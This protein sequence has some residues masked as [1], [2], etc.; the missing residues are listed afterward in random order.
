MAVSGAYMCSELHGWVVGW[1]NGW[2]G[3]QM[4]RQMDGWADR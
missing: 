4:G 3:G 1:V 2:M